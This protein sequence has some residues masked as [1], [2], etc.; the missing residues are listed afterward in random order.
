MNEAQK[1]EKFTD[2]LPYMKKK[3]WRSLAIY[4]T[5]TYDEFLE[6]V[7]K[8]YPEVKMEEIGSVESLKTI[9]KRYKGVKVFDEGKLRCFGVEFHTIAKKL[10]SGQALTKKSSSVPNVFGHLG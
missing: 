5:G 3:Y 6:D 4:G 2:F 8:S 1:K 7:F 9:C 10:M